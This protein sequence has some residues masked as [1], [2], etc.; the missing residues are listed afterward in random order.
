[1]SSLADKPGIFIGLL[2]LGFLVGT[3]GHIYK[4]NF[5]IGLGIAMVFAATVVIPGLVYFTD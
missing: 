5:A 2:V 3:A 4:S 1:V